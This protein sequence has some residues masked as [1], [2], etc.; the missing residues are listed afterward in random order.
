MSS[1]AS[2]TSSISW[3]TISPSLSKPDTK[4]TEGAG[5]EMSWRG[6]DESSS[7]TAGFDIASTSSHQTQHWLVNNQ[8]DIYLN[9]HSDEMTRWVLTQPRSDEMSGCLWHASYSSNS[10]DYV[11]CSVSDTTGDQLQVSEWVSIIIFDSR[12]IMPLFHLFVHIFS[13]CL[14]AC[15]QHNSKSCRQMGYF[16]DKFTLGLQMVKLWTSIPLKRRYKLGL[17]ANQHHTRDPTV[18]LCDTRQTTMLWLTSL[19]VVIVFG[20]RLRQ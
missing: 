12:T 15:P 5:G 9:L 4:V 11:L 17:A 6:V 7:S 8:Q 13:Y 10:S 3:T 16:Q 14:L 18:F 2:S 19:T 1:L 20:L